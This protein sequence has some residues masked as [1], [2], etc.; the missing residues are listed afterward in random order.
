MKYK[1]N[2]ER[3]VLHRWNTGRYGK[4]SGRRRTL[5]V[6]KLFVV[7]KTRRLYSASYVAVNVGIKIF[8]LLFSMVTKLD[9]SS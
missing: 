8:Y 4:D 7:Q 1:A 6:R 2:Q 3:F 5:E 9:L